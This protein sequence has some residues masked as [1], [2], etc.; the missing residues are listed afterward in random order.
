MEKAKHPAAFCGGQRA[1]AA[2]ELVV[3]HPVIG[4]GHGTPRFHPHTT[5]E[6]QS[7]TQHHR[8]Q[9]VAF[10]AQVLRHRAVVKRARQRRDEIDP[11]R[12][13]SLEKAAA[14]N[15]NHHIQFNRLRSVLPGRET[16]ALGRGPRGR[17][18]VP[19]T[20]YR[21]AGQNFCGFNSARCEHGQ[22]AWVG[23]LRIKFFFLRD[24]FGF[25]DKLF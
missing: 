12:R 20:P 7:R 13:P 24:F 5:A 18:S 23:R 19:I 10:K 1:A 6:W 22:W 15:L 21:S 3:A 2:N 9:Q 4:E 16:V 8:V 25:D 14:R 11:A 17:Y